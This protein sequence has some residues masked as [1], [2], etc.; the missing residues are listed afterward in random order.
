MISSLRHILLVAVLLLCVKMQA[1]TVEQQQQFTYYWYAAKQAIV[2]ERY[3]DAYVLLKF[4][5]AINPE[6]GHTMTCLGII[7]QGIG[8]DLKGLLLLN[9]AFE[10]D[11]HDQWFH[12]VKALLDINT[13]SSWA[14]ALI[15]L[16]K[17][18]EVQQPNCDEELLDQLQDMY[19]KLDKWSE[20]LAIQDELDKINGYTS[21]SA[22]LR[23]RIWII[24]KKPKKA[25]AEVNRYLEQDPTD[26]NLLEYK[27][28]I[29]GMTK[30]KAKELYPIYEQILEIN[31]HNLSILNDYAWTLATHKGDLN[32]AESMSAITIKEDPYNATFLDTYGWIMYM[33]GEKD[34]A[35]FYLTRAQMY[36]GEDNLEEI[37]AHIKK[38]KGEK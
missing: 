38:V 36:A 24:Q 30:A 29:M 21:Q 14:Q 28:G 26:V 4:C 22:I 10:A 37:N 11:P 15:V 33:K 8:N 27:V 2:E 9:D 25:L 12:Y 19:L 3:D 13:P 18:H 23:V 7:E 35:L 6:D 17:A 16:E 32:K 31:P 5:H 20:A 1:M 34:L